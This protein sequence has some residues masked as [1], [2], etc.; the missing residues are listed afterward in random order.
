MAT[1]LDQYLCN[2]QVNIL[3]KV[4]YNCMRHLHVDNPRYQSLLET[5]YM[6][7][8]GVTGLEL[9][10]SVVIRRIVKIIPLLAI[11]DSLLYHP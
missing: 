7:H 2:F 5:Y 10:K 3:H 1:F 8:T 6:L 9:F 4:N 11:T